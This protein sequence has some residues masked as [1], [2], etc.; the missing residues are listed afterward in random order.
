MPFSRLSWKLI[1]GNAAL[2]IAALVISFWL[3]V[4]EVSQRYAAR[5]HRQ[6]LS[7]AQAL[8]RT[9]QRDA[10][11]LQPAEIEPL[12]RAAAPAELHAAVLSPDGAPLADAGNGGSPQTR[13]AGPA[14]L[15]AALRDGG[16]VGAHRAADNRAQIVALARI[17]PAGGP[18]G[19]VLLTRPAWAPLSERGTVARLVSGLVLIAAVSVAVMALGLA[20]LWSGPL[21][22]I[23]RT[24][25]QLSRGDFTARAHLTASDELGTL[26]RALDEMR[27]RLMAQVETIDRQRGMLA[28]LLAQLR[29]GVI[30]V[31]EDERIV[32]MNPAA[33]N[34][35]Q[36]AGPETDAAR[37]AERLAGLALERAIPQHDLQ[38]LL[39]GER[40]D[41]ALGLG[42]ANA[43]TGGS[44]QSQARVQVDSPAGPIHLLARAVDIV[45]P[46]A[47]GSREQAEGR[48]LVLTDI[49][50]LERIYQVRT[51]FV[52]NASHE[53]RTPLSTIRTAVEALLAMDLRQDA[54][55]AA[56]FVGIIDR[57][58]ARLA[59]LVSDLLDLARLE[60]PRT[61]FDP[62]PIAW[63]ELVRE[64]SERFADRLAERNL[65]W[66]VQP[67]PTGPAP[68]IFA[69]PYLVQLVL[70]NL[71]DNAIKFTPPGGQIE[72]ALRNETERLTLTVADTGCGI[73]LE[74]Q[75][76][77]FERFY[78]V[79]RA[80]S[81]KERGTGLGLSI[82]R[83]AVAAM[84]GHVRLES[85]PGKGTVFYVTL[86]SARETR[87]QRSAPPAAV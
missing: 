66:V 24:A 69:H 12:L 6:L 52:T 40:A 22:R 26:A 1:L 60:S 87:P 43:E 49:T 79:E 74:D 56:K 61:R 19:V 81:G 16:Y 54:D 36:L 65:R 13:T 42:E 47:G 45:F 27:T 39:R 70:D 67:D 68:E 5:E 50:K 75:P 29:E 57:Q 34:L 76:R 25:R 32:L 2:L 9:L 82:V 63:R 18:R 20:R 46:Q 23:A 84:R 71:I 37:T 51:D 77:V 73:P 80:R 21:R 58:S 55:A 33:V 14:E 53:L 17:G 10:P 7:Q 4:E 28:S 35:L 86:P 64:I 44:P 59:A 62:Q 78:Q 31:G 38:R 11:G 8:A 41:D 3:I 83:H 85:T 72:L 30:V 15:A 48:L